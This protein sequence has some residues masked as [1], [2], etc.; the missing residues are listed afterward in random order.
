VSRRTGARCSPA[1]SNPRR[2]STHH[3]GLA[4]AG[5]DDWWRRGT[6]VGAPDAEWS[7]LSAVAEA[8]WSSRSIRNVLTPASFPKEKFARG[9]RQ[10]VSAKRGASRQPPVGAWSRRG[11]AG[12]DE[13]ER[14]RSVRHPGEAPPAPKRRGGS[15]SQPYKS[16]SL[17]RD[18]ARRTRCIGTSRP[19]RLLAKAAFSP[20]S[21]TRERAG[22]V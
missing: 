5:H 22:V 14:Q 15:A 10:G 3:H 4:S 8:S 2:T 16:Q 18:S 19:K 17:H 20:H 12:E 6:T 11:G 1:G 7:P 9:P 13:R 21:S